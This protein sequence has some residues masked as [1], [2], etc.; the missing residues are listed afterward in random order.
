MNHK[1][2]LRVGAVL[3]SAL[4][5]SWKGTPAAPFGYGMLRDT[6]RESGAFGFDRLNP[7]ARNGAII[8]KEL[9]SATLV[10]SPAA[11]DLPK[12]A[13]NGYEVG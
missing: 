11:A 5:P 1:I 12:S 2:R 9:S 4:P 8:E 3:V 13:Q 7:S 10:A 6:A